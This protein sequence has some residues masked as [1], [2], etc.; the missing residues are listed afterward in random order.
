MCVYQEI[1]AYPGLFSEDVTANMGKGD[2]RFHKIDISISDDTTRRLIS[3]SIIVKDGMKSQW[4]DVCDDL[5]DKISSN[6]H[7]FMSDPGEDIDANELKKIFPIHPMTVELVTKVAGI[8]ASGRSIFMFLKSNDDD[9]FRKYIRENGY[10]DWR[11]VTADYLWDYYFV[12]N[13]GGKKT[14]TKMAED[15]L[16]HYNK[17]ADKISDAKALRVFKAAMLLLATIGSGQSMKKSK[18]SRGIQATQKTLYDCFCGAIDKDSL[19]EY[20][21]SLCSDPL[22]VLVLAPDLHEGYRVELPYSG[23]GGELEAEIAT[24]KANLSVGKLFDADKHF[25]LELKKQFLTGDRAVV[26]RLVL[27]TCWGSTQ[28]ITYK[29]KNL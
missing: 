23:T 9:G 3:E 6:V 7:T 28:Q 4:S 10:Y 21:K 12:N 17:V 15:C 27:E 24:L 16:K 22:N 26:K 2:A 19:E 11:W 18:G 8:A 29:Y 1:Q 14:L 20:I 5:Y 25:G 13:S